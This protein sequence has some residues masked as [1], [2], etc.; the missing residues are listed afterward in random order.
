MIID[1]N[2]IDALLRAG[3]AA[4]EAPRPVRLPPPPPPPRPRFTAAPPPPNVARLLRIRVPV[5]VEIARRQ[6]PI[7]SLR[8]LSL[9]MILEFDRHIDDPADLRVNRHAIGAGEIVRV[10]DNFGLRVSSIGDANQR[11]RSLGR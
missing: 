7:A 11:I 5:V 4:P 10:G 9:G 2:E 3:E 6:M 1:Q 8:K